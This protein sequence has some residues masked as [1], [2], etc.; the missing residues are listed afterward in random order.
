MGLGP[1]RSDSGARVEIPLAAGF[2]AVLKAQRERTSSRQSAELIW[3]SI[4]SKNSLQ[5]AITTADFNH[6]ANR[7]GGN[8]MWKI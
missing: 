2:T 8:K 7:G 6:D 4:N 1:F 3:S 5:C